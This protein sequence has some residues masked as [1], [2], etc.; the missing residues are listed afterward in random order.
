MIEVRFTDIDSQGHAS[1]LAIASWVSHKRVQLFD[2]ALLLSGVKGLDHV[3]VRIEI[4]FK[5]EIKYPNLVL[6]FS[7]VAKV[8]GKSVTTKYEVSVKG[9]IAATARC[10]NVFF[11]KDG[12][13][14]IPENLRS[15]LLDMD[16]IAR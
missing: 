8:G 7:E 5:K 16:H 4:D 11:N 10:I 1:H 13:C 12:P 3:M 15:A 14:R 6:I 2:D 9:V